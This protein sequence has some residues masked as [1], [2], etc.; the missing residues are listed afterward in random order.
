M[1]ERSSH[2]D[3]AESMAG[4]KH[5]HGSVRQNARRKMASRWRVGGGRRNN[6]DVDVDVDVGE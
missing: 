5:K 3:E 1:A 2:D 6:I 4:F